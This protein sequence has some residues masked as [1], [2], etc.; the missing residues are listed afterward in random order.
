[1]FYSWLM[2]TNKESSDGFLKKEQGN[3]GEDMKRALLSGQEVQ[4]KKT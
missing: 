4:S 2:K 3:K 1:M